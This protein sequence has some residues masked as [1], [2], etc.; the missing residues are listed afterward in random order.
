MTVVLPQKSLAGA[1][2]YAV[3]GKGCI[4]C[5]SRWEVALNPMIHVRP[6]LDSQPYPKTSHRWYR[7]CQRV[8]QTSSIQ[9]L[10]RPAL[11]SLRPTVGT[12]Y[13]DRKACWRGTDYVIEGEHGMTESNRQTSHGKDDERSVDSTR[14][15]KMRTRPR[16][17]LTVG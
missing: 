14:R 7:N 11:H 5:E 1:L 13:G 17:S 2:W 6:T 3:M 16:A 10:D 9:S 8:L 4:R 12:D 15:L